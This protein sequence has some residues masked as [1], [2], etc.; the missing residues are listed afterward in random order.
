MKKV[1]VLGAGMISRPCIRY[2]LDRGDLLVT[3]ADVE[4]GKAA[5]R[6][7]GHERGA[8]VD[9]DAGDRSSVERL[10][11]ECD[12]AISI[13]PAAMHADIAALALAHGKHFVTASYISDAMK[14][15][16]ADVRTAG[17]TFLNEV[18]LDPG[19][20]HMSA[21]RIVNG[22]KEKGGTVTTFRSYCGGLPAPDA[23]NPWGYKFSWSPRG[24]VLAGRN[25]S[26]YLENGREVML[27]GEKLFS[28]NWLVPIP[29]FGEL[30]AYYNR[31]SI[32]YID[33]YGLGGVRN[34]MRATLRYYGWSFTMQKLADLGYFDLDAVASPPATYGEL[35][36]RLAGVESEPGLRSA[37]A[38]ALDVDVDSDTM[39][40]L[41]W[42]GLTS[43]DPIIWSAEF[44]HSPLDALANK[45][46]EKMQ[47]GAGER[48]LV[49][50]HHE[51]EGE[52]PSGKRELHASTL[53]QYGDPAGDTA[54]AKTVGLPTAIAA[55]MI[56]DGKITD[57]GVLIPVLPS[58]YEP[59]L[60]ELAAA[61]VGFTEKVEV[62][63]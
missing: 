15:L 62:L 5:E 35:T 50:M 33:L 39:T 43:D 27:P 58:V 56:L 3:V 2:L 41:D 42:L 40:R 34:M 13:L 51:I 16:D 49:V 9:L 36:A 38:R 53:I 55:T 4:P 48:D 11:S 24:V 22:I 63:Q 18:G 26:R 61:G 10:V 25:S 32:P 44:E 29:G 46:L 19:I 30:E 28:R 20:D 59:I 23:V 60:G 45:M 1:L 31:D 8:A 37:L 7:A 6:V 17:L 57:T 12:L 14:A 21:L 54:M 52:Y 47:Y